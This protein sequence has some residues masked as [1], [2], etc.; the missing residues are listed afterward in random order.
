MTSKVMT[1]NTYVNYSD[2]FI[3]FIL[4]QFFENPP[5]KM[6]T[7]L[8]SCW[9]HFNPKLDIFIFTI[10]LFV[11]QSDHGPGSGHRQSLRTTDTGPKRTNSRPNPK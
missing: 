5:Q 3:T 6:K 2:V 11:R 8:K 4:T 1:H 7:P 10:F 9:P